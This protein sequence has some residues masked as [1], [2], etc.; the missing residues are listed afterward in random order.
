MAPFW[1]VMLI[2]PAFPLL[3]EPVPI[4]GALILPPATRLTFPPLPVDEPEAIAGTCSCE[5]PS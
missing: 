4:K 5:V 3:K 2:F 1:L